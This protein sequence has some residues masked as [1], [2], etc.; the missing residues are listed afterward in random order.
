[1]V[2]HKHPIMETPQVRPPFLNGVLAIT[3][4]VLVETSSVGEKRSVRP[5]QQVRLYELV[6]GISTVDHGEFG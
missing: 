3:G 6:D 5:R 4:L 2:F 1:M